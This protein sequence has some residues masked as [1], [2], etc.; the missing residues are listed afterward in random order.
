[1]DVSERRR[2]LAPVVVTG[3]LVPYESVLRAEL[4][5]VGYATS[6]VR[7]AA[8]SMARLSGWMGQQ[9]LT[10]EELTPAAVEEFLDVRRR[11]CRVEGVARRWLGAVLRVLRGQGVVPGADLGDCTAVEALVSDYRVWLVTERG[12]AAETV[13]CYGIQ[14]KK[15]LAHL[16]DPLDVSLAGLDPAAVTAFMVGQA[17][18]ADSVWSAKALVTAVRSLLRFLHVQGL[19]SVSLTA[20]VPAVA[21]WRLSAL[22]RGLDRGQ[23]QA[24]LAAPD[25]ATPVGLRDRAVLTLLASLGL[26]GAEVAA[27]RLDDIDWRAG[28]IVVRG[29]GSRVERLPL[30]AT[31]GEAVAAYLTDA[32]PRCCC[33]TVFVTARAPHQPLRPHSIRA[34]MSRA[35][36]RAGLPRLGAH[37]LRHSLATD[38]LRAGAPLTEV[39][40]VLRHRSQLATSVYAK[41]DHEALRMLARPWPGGAR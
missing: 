41:V 12:L 37:R 1:M 5:R 33:A 20:A 19:T 13:R 23:V 27:L 35:C 16:S 4:A 18:T 10:A 36:Q 40:Q 25:P 11:R 2:G 26:R 30:P 15:F 8:G 22:P 31:A 34:I 29:K 24:L 9:G 38:M 28:E 17:T 6:S 39:G 21:G 14:A 32:R 3:P 7:E